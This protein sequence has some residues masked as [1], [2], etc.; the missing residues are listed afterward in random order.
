MDYL[1]EQNTIESVENKLTI[2]EGGYILNI[3][4]NGVC[5]Q[6]TGLWLKTIEVPSY[7]D[8]K[9]AATSNTHALF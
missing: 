8:E 5:A 7:Q 6:K 3:S 4:Q 1:C 2:R 9:I